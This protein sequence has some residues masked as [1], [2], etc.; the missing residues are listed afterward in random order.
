MKNVRPFLLAGL[1]FC[2]KAAMGCTLLLLP[3]TSLPLLSKLMGGTEVAPPSIIFIFLLTVGW[4]P[5]YLLRG[6][7]L[8]GEIKPFLVFIVAALFASAAGFFVFLPP[9]KGYTVLGAER[10]ALLTLAVG[11]ATYL[12]ISLWPRETIQLNWILKL[13]NI[14][15]AIILVWSL[16]EL[17]WILLRGGHYPDLM[18]RIQSVLAVRG[19]YDITFRTRVGGFTYEPSWLAHQLNVVFLPYWLAATIT[20]YTTAKKILHLSVENI[21][22]ALGFIVMF[23]SLSRIGLAA[24]LLTTAFAFYRLNAYG[25]RWLQNRLR[26]QPALSKWHLGRWIQLPLVLACLIIYLGAIAGFII[27]LSHF[28]KRVAHLL[29]WR[30]LPNSFLAFAQQ[31]DFAERVVYWSN[32]WSVFAQH[33]LLGVGLGNSGFFFQQYLPVISY[34]LNEI[35]TLI[36]QSAV[37]PNIK[38]LWVRLLAETGLVGFATFVAWQYIL[39]RAGIFLRANRSLI[40]RTLGWMGAFAVIAFLAEGFSVDSFALPYLWVAMGILTA[41]SSVARR[42]TT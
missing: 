5:V 21:L 27:L 17:A 25:I 1:D 34:G 13:I 11:C 7:N 28:D 4:L 10:D 16:L 19:F 8:P 38:S 22:L 24:F 9:Y 15:G 31:G 20:G 23:F 26:G 29:N 33:P 18:M 3:F 12:V 14:S 40:L 32:G 35:Q 36:N 30:I 39:W 41:A 37:L 42:E 2:A 6:G